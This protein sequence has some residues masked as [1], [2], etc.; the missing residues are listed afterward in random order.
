MQKPQIKKLLNLQSEALKKGLTCLTLYHTLNSLETVIAGKEIRSLV[1]EA[2]R[3]EGIHEIG[4]KDIHLTIADRVS[5]Y[6]QRIKNYKP[7]VAVFMTFD[8]ENFKEDDII[9]DEN[10][11]IYTSLFSPVTKSFVDEIFDLSSIWNML[12]EV[13]DLVVNISYKDTKIYRFEDQKLDLI[14]TIENEILEKYEDRFTNIHVTSS[15]SSSNVPHS[16][17]Y[18]QEKEDKI[19]RKIVNDMIAEVKNISNIP[20]SY[21]KLIVVYSPDFSDDSPVIEDNLKH[22]AKHLITKQVNIDY[23]KEASAKINEIVSD[24]LDQKIT[25]EIT[26]AKTDI[27]L[28][29]Q[30]DWDNILEYIRNSNVHKL[31]LKEGSVASGY[32]LDKSLPYS[33]E[34]TGSQHVEDVIPWIIKSVIESSGEIVLL[35]KDDKRID[36][37]I[38]LKPR[39]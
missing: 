35:S 31:Y 1:I 38:A 39:Y 11:I 27:T 19:T 24:Y 6:L 32:L 17:G 10:L 5:W 33:R 7:G 12:I 22:L 13:N 25:S 18:A 34:E 9:P 29:L 2:L 37:L 23:E 36:N 4:T 16:S 14:K 21:D 15:S 8:L 28:T 3:A 20:L 30:Q 26:E